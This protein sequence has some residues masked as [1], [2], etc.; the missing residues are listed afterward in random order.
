MAHRNRFEAGTH[1][2]DV[3]R[4]GARGDA[5]VQSTQAVKDAISACS[6]AGGGTV[7]VPAGTYLCGPLRLLSNMTLHLA[8]GAV[9]QGSADLADYPREDDRWSAESSRAGLVS[10]RDAQ[11]VAITGRGAIDG[12]GPAFVDPGRAHAGRDED[13]SRTRQG[14]AFMA[15]V[16]PL[17][18]GPFAHAD[19]PGNLIRIRGCENVLIE[20]VTIRNSPTWT[21][22]VRD[23]TG[24][25]VAGVSI[26]SHGS[27]LRVPNDDGLN[28]R[29]S[30]SVRISDCDIQTGDDCVAVAG[31]QDLTVANCT[32]TS[33]SAGIR[34]GFSSGLTRRCSFSNLV[35]HDSNRGLLLNVRGDGSI[36][37]LQFTDIIISTCLQGGHWWGKGE[38]IH[39]SAMPLLVPADRMGHISSVRFANIL[40]DGEGGIVVHGCAES[41]IR[42]LGFEQVR[43]HLRGGRL[44]DACGGNFDFRAVADLSRALFRH[45]IPAFYAAH[46]EGLSVHRLKVE[47]G[48]GVPGFFTHAVQCEHCRRVAIEGLEGTA[49]REGLDAVALCDVDGV[50]AG[51]GRR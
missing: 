40:A 51:P 3:T 21:V 25:R 18:Y 7:L 50:A 19:R 43:L 30:R 41:A 34:V 27:G 1:V 13:L 12:A 31:C 2:F 16:D 29:G 26:H 49:A 45:D 28:L 23:C 35:I 32:L 4:F 9:L 11:N 44:Q 10:V 42:D 22:N 36:E 39:V 15:G 20:G 48:D 17:E 6:A 24:V 38:P 14:E 5:H 37:E 33:R 8:A 46:V 47:W